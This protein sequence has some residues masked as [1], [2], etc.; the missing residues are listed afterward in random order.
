MTISGNI[1]FD[2]AAA[3]TA[4]SCFLALLSRRW[5]L[6]LHWRQEAA[7][8]AFACVGVLATWAVYLWAQ[9]FSGFAVSFAMGGLGLLVFF[10]VDK[11][12]MP[13]IDTIRELKNGNTAYALFLL[14]ICLVIAAAI[15]AA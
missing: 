15:L 3:L 2:I 14:G 11:Y 1:A 12:L 7:I 8:T 10:A 6:L 13:D 9:K 5:S 4:F